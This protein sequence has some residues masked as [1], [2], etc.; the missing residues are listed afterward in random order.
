[1]TPVEVLLK[2]ADNEPTLTSFAEHNPEAAVLTLSGAMGGAAVR[3]TRNQPTTDVL[4]GIL[5][6]VGTGAGALGGAAIGRAADPSGS[7]A[8][9][10]GG[11]GGLI[12]FLASRKLLRGMEPDTPKREKRS[13]SPALTALLQAKQLSDN[14]QYADKHLR[15]RGLMEQHPN[16]FVIDSEQ[17]GMAGLTFVPLGFKIHAPLHVIPKNIKRQDKSIPI[18]SPAEVH[19]V[20]TPSL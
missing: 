2:Y 1:M 12:S 17:N 7:S 3:K 8:F 6:G 14:K 9:I 18:T 11:L 20:E 5:T 16:D 13:V 15:L 10:G 19:N 4:R